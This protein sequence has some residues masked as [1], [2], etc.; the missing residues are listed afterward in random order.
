MNPIDIYKATHAVLNNELDDE[1]D[2]YASDDGSYSSGSDEGTSGYRRGGYHPVSVG[3]VFSSGRYTV[4]SKLGW[5]HFSTVW[6]ADDSLSGEEVA[7]KIVKSA[8]HYTEAAE[9]EVT[10]LSTIAGA[11]GAAS[12]P[13]VRLLDNFYHSGPHGRHVVMVTEVLG[14][15]LLDL[16]K[17]HRYKGAPLPIVKYII[18]QILEGL[19]FLHERCGIIHTDVKPENVLLSRTIPR[20][21]AVERDGEDKGEGEDGEGDRRR[22]DRGGS[23]SDG[24]DGDDEEDDG[25]L[26]SEDASGPL[27]ERG[28]SATPASRSASGS[29]TPTFSGSGSQSPPRT[30]AKSV[31]SSAFDMMNDV[32]QALL[33]VAEGRDDQRSVSPSVTP[34]VSPEVEVNP[35]IAVLERI[36]A[37]EQ[38]SPDEWEAAA[39]HFGLTHANQTT[40]QRKKLRR[41]I[42]NL[43]GQALADVA[44][45]TA[46]ATSNSNGAGRQTATTSAAATAAAAAKAQR[47]SFRALPASAYGEEADDA[48]RAYLDAFYGVKL[49]DLGNACWIRK[50]FTDDVQ[51]RQYRAPEVILGAEYS[52]PC[53]V[54]SV[55]CMVFE[56]ATG[57][58]L[59][60]PKD[61]KNYGKSDDHLALITELIGP[62]PRRV[63][64]SGKH[65]ADF[66]SSSGTLRSIASLK[67]WPLED[68]LMEKYSYTQHEADC[69]GSFLR[70]MLHW[71]P[72]LRATATQSLRHPFLTR[73]GSLDPA[74]IARGPID[75]PTEQS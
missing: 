61:G 68:V 64:E 39:Q 14:S 12:A 49:V 70:P 58:L 40:N 25:E 31:V 16:I 57:D 36:G 1:E 35:V 17:A 65:A 59:F 55:A 24:D 2:E 46:S 19:A 37:G 41:K 20:A 9:D 52:T 8:S 18:R 23:D 34:P 10:I 26:D 33:H 73:I 45:G 53:D 22:D 15:S 44:A 42:R 72:D 5:G 48:T 66:Y 75:T 6:L 38:V 30:E 47:E 69:M 67:P 74:L 29:V 71:N 27:G 54:W 11:P 32:A 50:H 3:D 4:K 60:E 51:T 13:V 62:A 28:S 21:E 7:L 63:R 43:V 56:L